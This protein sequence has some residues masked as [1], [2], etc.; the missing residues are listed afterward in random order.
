MLKTIIV[1]KGGLEQKKFNS[2][3]IELVAAGSESTVTEDEREH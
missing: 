2:V 3:A 1:K